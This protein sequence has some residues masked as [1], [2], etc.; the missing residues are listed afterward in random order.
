MIECPY[1]YIVVSYCCVLLY[2]LYLYL[3]V[4]VDV[5]VSVFVDC[6]MIVGRIA[7][8]VRI[9]SLGYWR[10]LTLPACD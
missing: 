4:N 3:Y 6:I 1:V 2:M 5:C 8:L 7:A 10:N 9:E